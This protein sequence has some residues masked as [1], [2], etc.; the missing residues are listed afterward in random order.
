MSTRITEDVLEALP[1]C[2]LKAYFQ[3]RGEQGTR[4]GYEQLLIEQRANFRL[5]A[6]EKIRREYQ[7][8]EVETELELSLVNLRK[9]ALFIVGARLDDDRYAVHFDALRKID[10]CSILGDSRYEPVM[11]APRSGFAPPIVNSSPRAQFFWGEFRAPFPA[12]GLST[13]GTIARERAFV[14]GRR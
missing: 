4:S 14:S 10:G 13:L 12:E 6:I 2:R 1:Y 5:K 7:E 8:P 9:G 11:F 3:L